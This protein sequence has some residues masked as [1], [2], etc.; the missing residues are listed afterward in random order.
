MSFTDTE[1]LLTKI[2]ED[3]KLVL[4]RAIAKAAASATGEKACQGVRDLAQAFIFLPVRGDLPDFVH[5]HGGVVVPPTTTPTPSPSPS[6]SP[7]PA[8]GGHAHGQPQP[9]SGHTTSALPSDLEDRL[10]NLLDKAGVDDDAADMG[11][12]VTPTPTPA[13]TP[14]TPQQMRLERELEEARVA[15]IDA[16]AKA[17]KEPIENS[18]C[19]VLLAEAF[20][21]LPGPM[22]SSSGPSGGGGG[23]HSHG[24]PTPT[25]TPRPT[26]VPQ[27]PVGHSHG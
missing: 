2:E 19:L 12:V 6:P 18:R 10:D 7:T 4:A 15:L 3:V 17:A 14:V 9:T 23:A 20:N 21:L 27:P 11:A 25:P 5:S 22:G 1:N 8:P 26:P 16:L 24:T 13:P